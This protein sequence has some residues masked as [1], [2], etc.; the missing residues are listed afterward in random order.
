[1]FYE[2]AVQDV[3]TALAS[4]KST[5]ET[6]TACHRVCPSLWLPPRFSLPACVLAMDE[7]VQATLIRLRA[8]TGVSDRVMDLII[9]DFSMLLA[10]SALALGAS[11]DAVLDGVG[12]PTLGMTAQKLRV[13]ERMQFNLLVRDTE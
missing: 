12:V 8:V 6:G 4:K 7:E 11:P 10:R 5:P 3:L 9:S 2:E 1:M 13:A